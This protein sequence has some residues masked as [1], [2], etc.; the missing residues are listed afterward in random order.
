MVAFVFL[1]GLSGCSLSDD[2]DSGT[3]LVAVNPPADAAAFN[4]VKISF[5][6][7]IS[8]TSNGTS[9][10]FSY[11]NNSGDSSIF[12]SADK[13]S[14]T[15]SYTY[16]VIE[17]ARRKIDFVFPDAARNFSIELNGFFGV[18]K[19]VAGFA[20]T[21]VGDTSN[22]AYTAQ[23]VSGSLQGSESATT[24]SGGSQTTGEQ[25][26]TPAALVGKVFDLTFAEAPVFSPTP[27]VPAGFPYKD[28]NVLK[29]TFSSSNILTVGDDYRS[30]GLPRKYAD[31]PEYVW[32]DAVNKLNY[33]VLLK[34]DGTLYKIKVRA[35]TYV[36]SSDDLHASYYGMFYIPVL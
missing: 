26:S 11:F 32:Y 31:S 24:A 18:G 21:K 27:K 16:S 35:D 6:P 3:G 4:G 30:V 9:N 1:L 22:T 15:G 25:V 5:N 28:G 19:V 34:D 8:F 36:Y 29:F 23:I 13:S 20:V 17:G 33:C 2:D 7:T 14:L 10:E 12:P